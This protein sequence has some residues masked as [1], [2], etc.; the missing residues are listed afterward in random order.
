MKWTKVSAT[1]FFGRMAASFVRSRVMP[2]RGGQPGF[3]AMV[4]GELVGGPDV[5][6]ESVEAAMTGAEVH[7]REMFE[8]LKKE[9]EG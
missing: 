2:A 9:L 5:R 3:V 4:N 8:I 6:F 1:D 7:V